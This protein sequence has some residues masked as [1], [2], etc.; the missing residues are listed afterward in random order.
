MDKTQKLE[1]QQQ[2]DAYMEKYQVYD[3]MQGLLRVLIQE[4]PKDPLDFLIKQLSRPQVKRAFIIGYPGCNKT[5]IAQELANEYNCSVISMSKVFERQIAK[6]TTIGEKI[7]L[8]KGSLGVVDDET[9]IELLLKKLKRQE[10]KGKSTIIAGFPINVTQAL[11]LQSKGIV[12]TK[13]FVLNEA[14]EVSCE[15][16]LKKLKDMSIEG[17]LETKAK[18]LTA[19]Y[20]M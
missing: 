4:K 20:Y 16:A 6:K 8:A 14:F 17:K 18:D 1:Y 12:P 10:Q 5:K 7:E 15:K 2:L 11:A 13:L 3:L 9:V 19:A